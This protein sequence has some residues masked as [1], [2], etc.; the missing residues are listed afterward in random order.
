MPHEYALTVTILPSSTRGAVSPPPP[1]VTAAQPSAARIAADPTLPGLHAMLLDQIGLSICGGALPVGAILSIDDLVEQ[2][3]VSRSVV[4][5]VLRVLASMGLVASRRRVGTIILPAAEWNVY[6]PQVIRWRLAS[7]GRLGQLR[8][9]TEL[10]GAV[11]PEAALLAAHRATPECASDI[12]GTAAKLW[13]AA[14]GDD[15]EEFL[16]IDIEFHRQVLAAS[17]NEMFVKLHELIAVV[18]TGRHQHGLMPH[19]PDEQAMQL[20]ADVAQ[21]IQ[22]HDGDRARAAMHKIMEQAM[23]QMRMWTQAA[24]K[25]Q[26]F[27]TL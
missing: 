26:L 10:R 20:H 17:G 27:D 2:H 3:R 1:Q 12:V 14:Q 8:S 25:G 16:R 6:D 13:A 4:R 24:D 18:L 23:G 22:R 9:L 21:A 11:E 5:E 15:E 19:H 7:D